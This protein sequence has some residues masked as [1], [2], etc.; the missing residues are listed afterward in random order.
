MAAP[1]GSNGELAPM[2]Q[3]AATLF[4]RTLDRLTRV[5]RDVAGSARVR[6]TGQLRPDLPDDDLV[7]LKKQ[8]DDCLNHPGGEVSQRAQAAALGRAFLAL[9]GEGRRR[10]Y[11]MLLN[12]YG[13]EREAVDAAMGQVQAAADPA[14]RHKAE[15][16]LAACL[17]PPRLSLLT[18]F[19][20]LPEGVKFLVDLRADLQAHVKDDRALKPLDD[21]LRDLLAGW[22]DIGFLD[23]ERITWSASATLLEKLI[24]YEAVHEIRSW[25]DLKNRLDSDRRCFAFFHPRMPEEPLIFVEV[26]L[27]QGI[28]ASVQALLDEQAPALDTAR[29]DTAIFYSISNCQRG[30]AGVSFGDFLIKRVVDRLSHE[31]PQL[32][33][34]STLSPIPGFRDWFD[35]TQ[36]ADHPALAAGLAEADWHL[37]PARSA[38]LAAPLTRLC[39]R[40]LAEEKANG[41]ALDRVAHFHLSNG[42]RIEQVNWLGDT[43]AAGL[44]QA[45][46]LMVNY[47]YKLDEIDGNHE[48]YVAEGTVATSSAV[49]KLLKG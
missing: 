15:R 33:L 6:L 36:A 48:A 12:E 11:T 16:A 13:T 32:K 28:A 22:F 40:Y 21:E 18:H 38:A 43:S 5:L 46:G 24:A 29:A 30:L 47:R 31:L 44:A 25:T 17:R 42:A 1:F 45:Y 41:R 49:R 27:T 2:T 20:A 34:Y 4:D 10:F 8:I 26:A 3:P 39:A 7:R 19:N 35:R 14:A 37:D 9:S 23:L